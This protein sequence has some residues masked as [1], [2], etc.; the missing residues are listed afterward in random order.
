M[1]EKFD[2]YHQWLGIPASE[3]P[4]NHYRLLGVAL[5]EGDAAV[6]SNAA[7]RQMAHLRNFQTGKHVAESQRLLNEVAAAKLCL[8]KAAKKEA[9]DK[10]LRARLACE[11]AAGKRIPQAV[12]LEPVG[13][14]PQFLADLDKPISPRGGATKM[15][16]TAGRRTKRPRP[17]SYLIV[18]MATATVATIAFAIWVLYS[19][20]PAPGGGERLRADVPAPSAAPATSTAQRASTAA[21]PATAAKLSLA[22]AKPSADKPI[23][24]EVPKP[25]A[26]A[27]ENPEDSTAPPPSKP[28]PEDQQDSATRP[29]SESQPQKP[30]RRQKLA[31]PSKEAQDRLNKKIDQ[32]YPR[33]KTAAGALLQAGLD[34]ESNPDEQFML[35]WRAA[36]TARNAGDVDVMLR[37]VDSIVAAG[38]DVNP[39]KLKSG[40]LQQLVKQHATDDAK[41][42]STICD[43]CV[44]FALDAAAN[45]ASDEASKLLDSARPA[46]SAAVLHSSR[47]LAAAKAALR[48]ARLPAD[49]AQQ[50]ANVATAQTE[51][52]VSKSALAAVVEGVKALKQILSEQA[53]IHAAEEKLKTTPDDPAA[54]R[55]VGSWYCFEKDNWAEGLKLLAK[56]S[57][58][59]LK[60]LAIKELAGKPAT[61]AEKIAH[62]D[63]WWDL[64]EKSS[65]KPKAAM[66]KFACN[67]YR[68]ALTGLPDGLE[69]TRVEN[70]VQTQESEAAEGSRQSRSPDADRRAAREV[71]GMYQS[72]LLRP[73]DTAVSGI[74]ELRANNSIWQKSNLKDQRIG[75]W[76]YE[77]GTVVITFTNGPQPACNLKSTAPGLY[78]GT[79]KDQSG[80]RTVELKKVS[81]IAVWQHK[82]GAV[83]FS[84]DRYWSNGHVDTLDGN[85][86]WELSGSRLRC[87]S[88]NWWWTATLSPDG[89]S[90][91]GTNST[92]RHVSGTLISG[93][94]LETAHP[95][96]EP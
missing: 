77:D 1:T 21:R 96:Q 23:P 92:A 78:V 10:S 30:L 83:V 53:V 81:V 68:E 40:L 9:Y 73:G 46:G 11:D 47:A 42:W 59:A 39:Y 29:P 35:L 50:T 72:T 14:D 13:L 75:K 2:P 82:I 79:Y 12:A 38:F 70:R 74:I 7:D 80:N 34:D 56:C 86:T 66:R 65:G 31:P 87:R 44:D 19:T 60:V 58:P 71:A 63:P 89:R 27:P 8:L 28:D 64:A 36:Q 62:G 37:A 16:L 95:K 32:A 15:P 49:I 52:E 18:V 85:I 41:S 67:Y 51:M 6:I 93:S 24:V 4:P 61:A 33:E 55:I 84:T 26:E 5:F 76:K 25:A 57:D 90:Y 48:R 3:Q 43:S 88:P 20:A 17:K 91:E 69:K 94:L 45:G 54:C 22:K